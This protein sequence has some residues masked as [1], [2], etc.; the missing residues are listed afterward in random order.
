[1]DSDT[2]S[3]KSEIRRRD[4]ESSVLLLG[5]PP[6]EFSPFY[7]QHETESRKE[8]QRVMA[9]NVGIEDMATT[10]IAFVDVYTAFSAA[11]GDPAPY[12]L[13]DVESAYWD[14]CQGRCLDPVDS[15]L[16]WDNIHLTGGTVANRL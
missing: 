14:V 1:M 11:M 2:A 15:Y 10:D 12:H 7:T 3:T 4:P 5:L 13:K 6:I 8:K 9:Y 16:W